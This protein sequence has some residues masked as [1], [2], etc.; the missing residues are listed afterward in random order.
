MYARTCTKSERHAC[1]EINP[2]K[3]L[4]NY[5][6]NVLENLYVALS[7]PHELYCAEK[8]TQEFQA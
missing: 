3:N 8:R 1:Y 6:H 4:N 7:L 5:V 2:T